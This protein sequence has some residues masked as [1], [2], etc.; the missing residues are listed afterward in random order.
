MNYGD[1]TIQDLGAITGT[2]IALHHV[3]QS[4]GPSPLR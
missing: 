4:A 3:Y 2:A 1:G